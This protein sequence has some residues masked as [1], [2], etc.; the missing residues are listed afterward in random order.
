MDGLQ[1]WSGPWE[2]QPHC[3]LKIFA[4]VKTFG[5]GAL[6]SASLFLP[7]TTLSW[8][9]SLN[10]DSQPLVRITPCHFAMHAAIVA[11]V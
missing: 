11:G 8:G 6:H 10:Q 2:E 9:I 3:F 5:A 1:W 4:A 7:M